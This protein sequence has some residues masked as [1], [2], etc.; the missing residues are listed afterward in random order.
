MTPTTSGAPLLDGPLLVALESRW[1]GQGWPGLERRRRGLREKEID[2]ATSPLGLRLPLE[3]RR[4]WGWHDGLSVAPDM[5]RK[6]HELGGPGFVYL[7]LADAVD[8]Y[9]RMRGIAKELAATSGPDTIEADGLWH[10]MWFPVTEASHGGIVACDCTDPTAMRTPIR[11][12]HWKNVVL[13][14]IRAR[15]FG[16]MVTWWIEAI[17]SGAWRY[18]AEVA[19][20]RY[21]WER[22]EPERELTGL[23]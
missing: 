17:D 2:A 19:A 5:P 9:T 20:W 4:W 11:A 10:P 14:K 7:T 15:S 23:V 8:V 16:E 1:R 12:V 13:G 18:D 3:A 22:L 6:D 21:D